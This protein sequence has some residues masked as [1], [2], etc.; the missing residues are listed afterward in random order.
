MPSEQI[1]LVEA[2]AKTRRMLQVSLEQVGYGV[3]TARDGAEALAQLDVGSPALVVCATDLPKLDGYGLVRRMKNHAEWS[4]IPVIFMIAGESIED[5]IRGLELGVEDYLHKPVF[6]RELVGRVQVLLARRVRDSLSESAAGTRVSA[7][8]ADL[9]P[10]DLFE[11]MEAGRQTGTL[12]IR[13][14]GRDGEVVFDRGEMIDARLKN[15]RGEEAVFRMLTWIDGGFEVELGSIDTDRTIESKTR[16][17][18]EAGIRHAAEFHRLRSRLPELSA[19]L[20]VDG[21]QLVAMQSEI[22]D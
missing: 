7:S 21:G 13:H 3:S 15:L 2:E 8:L 20:E 22:P 14:E 19:L 5:K 17:V 4:H 10:I 1:L 6:V 11:S 18:I 9:A 16:A 12:R